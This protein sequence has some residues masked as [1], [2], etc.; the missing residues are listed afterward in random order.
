M[1]Y[2]MTLGRRIDPSAFERLLDSHEAAHLLHVHP[3][4]VKRMARRGELAGV[5]FGKIWR[6]RVSA[7]EECVQRLTQQSR[8]TTAETMA[9]SPSAVCAVRDRRM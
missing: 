7:L 8:S 3:E 1:A 4:T 2:E 6:F 9:L 5:K